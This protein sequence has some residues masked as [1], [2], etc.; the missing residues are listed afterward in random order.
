MHNGEFGLGIDIGD[1][2]VAAAI[3]GNDGGAARPAEPLDLGG[4]RATAPAWF[5]VDADGEVT[6]APTDDAG[7][8]SSVMARIG[9]PTPIYAGDRPRA[10]AEVAAGAVQ[11]IREIAAQRAGRP[12]SWTVVAVP[13][14]WGGHRRAVLARALEA[15]G[16]PRFSLVSGA[17]AAAS[18]H[19]ARGD[20]PAE[21]TVAV[22]D[23]GARTLDLA[24]VGPTPDAPLDHLALP[25]AARPWGGRDVDDVLV[26]HVRRWT[27]PLEG[28]AGRS[29]GRALRAACVAA[30][31]EL[32]AETAVRIDLDGG[33]GGPV[34]LTREEL[35]ELIADP[36]QASVEEVVAAVAAAGLAVEDLDAV[37]LAGGSV[38]LPLV[39]EALSGELGRPLVVAAEPALTAALGAAAL[40]SDALLADA[41]LAALPEGAPE[42]L[43]A[44]PVSADIAPVPDPATGPVPARR[45]RGV[46]PAPAAVAPPRRPAAGR[47]GQPATGSRIRRG[48]AVTGLSLGLLVLPPALAGVLGVDVTATPTGEGVAEAQDPQDTGPVATGPA[49]PAGGAAVHGAAAPPAGWTAATADGVVAGTGLGGAP[50]GAARPTP[51]TARSGSG[52]SATAPTSPARA[53]PSASSPPPATGAAAP[54]SAAPTPDPSPSPEPAPTPA[55]L[56]EPSPSPAPS[57]PPE[58]SPAPTPEPSPEPSTAPPPPDSGTATPDPATP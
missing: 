16:V 50:G 23:L 11:R 42:P 36:A 4:E 41:L 29:R 20:L 5:A 3:C 24:V 9:S 19:V 12:D 57:P 37:V 28:P 44:P 54:P 6:F 40:A 22:Y 1:A 53:T 51:A 32:S 34:R 31:E 13:P 46:R 52:S 10:A 49:D 58:P 18:H 2:S 14:S 17:V 8:V 21:P 45:R 33:T 47:P 26:G 35:D 15:A 25:P 38:R 48:A 39:A 56:P 27:G 55:P 30:K 43:A 7:A